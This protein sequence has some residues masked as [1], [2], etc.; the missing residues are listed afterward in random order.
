MIKNYKVETK[1]DIIKDLKEVND[2][3]MKEIEKYK[4]LVTKMDF[5]VKIIVFNTKKANRRKRDQQH[6]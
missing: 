3:T 4:M 2:K 1:Q 6:L 5:I